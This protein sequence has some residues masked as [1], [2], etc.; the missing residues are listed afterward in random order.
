MVDV[1]LSAFT[2][3]QLVAL[4]AYLER[5]GHVLVGQ[6]YLG[7]TPYLVTQDVYHGPNKHK[8]NCLDWIPDATLPLGGK[9]RH[10]SEVSSW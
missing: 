7:D 5:T 10:T 4:D 6:D 8:C 2:A 1:N 3:D 9:W